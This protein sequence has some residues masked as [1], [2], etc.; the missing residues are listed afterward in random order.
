MH[1]YINTH[2]HEHTHTNKIYI[3]INYKHMHNNLVKNIANCF[4]GTCS[5]FAKNKKKYISKINL[6]I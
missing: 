1:T 4:F 6:V 3:Q 2:T 5:K